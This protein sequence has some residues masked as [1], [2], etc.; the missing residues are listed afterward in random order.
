MGDAKRRRE[1]EV[2]AAGERKNGHVAAFATTEVEEL[3]VDPVA[4]EREMAPP[5]FGMISATHLQR[6]QLEGAAAAAK[7]KHALDEW[8]GELTGD[9][10]AAISVEMGERLRAIAR[11]LG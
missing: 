11:G 5:R 8:M 9:E 10:I 7:G 2:I 6:L 1:P 3:I 4:H